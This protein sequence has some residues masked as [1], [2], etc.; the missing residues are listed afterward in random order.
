MVNVVAVSAHRI[1]F[2]CAQLIAL[3]CVPADR[4]AKGKMVV[5]A[6]IVMPKAKDICPDQPIM[7]IHLIH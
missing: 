2:T 6:A 7:T 3:C 5:V 4:C 1:Y